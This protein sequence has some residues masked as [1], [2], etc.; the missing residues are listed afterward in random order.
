MIRADD[1]VIHVRRN[2]Y[3]NAHAVDTIAWKTRRDQYNTNALACEQVRSQYT[4]TGAQQET[5]VATH[6]ALA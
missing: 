4:A 6:R 2:G 3:E 5:D 1:S